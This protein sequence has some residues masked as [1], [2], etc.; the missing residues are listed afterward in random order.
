MY[1]Y[2]YLYIYIYDFIKLF[3]IIYIFKYKME[4]TINYINKDIINKH[5]EI[6]RLIM[7]ILNYNNIYI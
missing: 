1:N 2:I 3:N 5:I 7:I 4:S 6:F